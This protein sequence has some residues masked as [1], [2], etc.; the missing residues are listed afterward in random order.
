MNVNLKWLNELVDIQNIPIND[1]V[2]TLSLHAVEVEG[3]GKLIEA[4]NIV[5][6][7]VLT[8]ELHPNSDHLS[9]LTVDVGN[10]ILE[11]VCGAPNVEAGQYVIVALEGAVLPGG[12][13]IK[14]SKIRGIYSNGMVC[15]LQELG[16]EKKYVSEEYVDGI[17]YFKEPQ[18]IGID[19]TKALY[20]D[21]FIINI[22]IT[23]NRG[24]LLSMLGVAIEFSALFNRPLKRLAYDL[25]K[26]K[27]TSGD[28]IKVEIKTDKCNTY[29]AQLIKDVK[30]KESPQ[31]LISRLIA[32]GIRPI[33]NCVDITNYILALFGQ[34]LHAFDYDVLGNEIVIR[35]ANE[36]ESMTTLDGIKR[37]L[38]PSDIVIT[39]GK[40]PVALAGVMG[41]LDTEITERTKNIVI[42]AAVFDPLTIRKT[43][44]RLG[45]RS[46][47]SYR[48]ERGVDLNR[49]KL[50]LDY[51]C[52]LFQTLADGKVVDEVNFDG[53]VKLPDK[54]IVV[55]EKDVEN[56]LGI[57]IPQDTINKLLTSLGFTVAGNKV[58]VPNRRSDINIKEDLIEE[59]GRLY[60][61]DKL[62]STLP[63]DDMVGE[64]TISQ[65]NIRNI[66]ML[67]SNIGLNEVVT[68]SL[69][70]KNK[71]NEFN[72]LVE[73]NASSIS[74]LMPL[75]EEHEYFRYS[76]VPSLIDVCK[77]NFSRKNTNLALFEIG[78]I[79]YKDEETKENLHLAGVMANE[80]SNTLWDKK[81]EVVDFYLVKG[82]LDLVFSKLGIDVEYRALTKD[83]KELHPKRTA[84]IVYNDKI[85]GYLGAI[86]PQY[87]IENDLEGVYVFEINLENIINQEPKH[88]MYKKVSK[89][90]SVERD[91]AIVLKRDI[92]ASKVLS[93][94]KNAERNI[95]EDAVIFD[96]YE[97]EHVK[98]DEKSI[99]CK[100][101]F[102]SSVALTDE[103]INSKVNRIVKSLEYHLGATLRG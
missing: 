80:F 6:G 5:V 93:V 31:W 42:E 65:K 92:P 48:F 83:V 54:E 15:S 13:K 29:Y 57:K 75:S 43:S 94:I 37:D 62:L 64:F 86:H 46:E 2:N 100:L 85:I 76:L 21:D 49:T 68:Y 52:Y 87:A 99:A 23:P 28:K 19:A 3:F 81:Q 58:Y 98:E 14:R 74:L 89:L 8:K 55:T 101:K 16:I 44:S 79:Y 33:N 53:I 11:I 56:L 84:E 32:F 4:N 1:I 12:F 7:H 95:L 24:D 27:A 10:E 45:L 60:G 67:L 78:N 82:V 61:Y 30:I 96:V 25:V 39:D 41:G 18:E 66:K 72:L 38:L 88:I 51:A 17:F 63:K 97:G 73:E 59:I 91:I 77:Y 69:V 9:L 35:N 36:N 26:T 70:S 50:A 20:L 47:S 103:E 40:R 102:T 71:L 22:D 90:P 34:P